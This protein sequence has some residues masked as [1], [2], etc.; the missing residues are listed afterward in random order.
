MAISKGQD[1]RWSSSNFS[2]DIGGIF[3]LI[4]LLLM[5]QVLRQLIGSSSYYLQGFVHP[6]CKKP[7][8]T[9]NG[10]RFPNQ[11]SPTSLCCAP[12]SRSRYQGHIISFKSCIKLGGC[13]FHS[14][15]CVDNIGGQHLPNFCWSFHGFS[16]KIFN[17]K[18]THNTTDLLKLDP[19][20]H[21]TCW[22]FKTFHLF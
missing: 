22:S 14:K 21:L 13:C 7:P 3:R 18:E 4:D 8:Q 16:S 2:G 12:K 11:C 17:Q 1:H 15:T 9:S 19:F 20:P 5:A 10:I 6:I